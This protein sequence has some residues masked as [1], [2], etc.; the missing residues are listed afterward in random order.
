MGHR[1]NS[2]IFDSVHQHN[3][4]NKT[5]R[6]LTA[7]GQLSFEGI[8]IRLRWTVEELQQ[9]VYVPP[10]CWGCIE[11]KMLELC[12]RPNI[13]GPDCRCNETNISYHNYYLLSPLSLYLKNQ[14]TTTKMWSFIQLCD[15]K[16]TNT[17]PWI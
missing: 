14:Q 15:K 13:Y 16:Q 1:H 17:N 2:N 6:A 5:R 11:P 10:T 12:R 8:Y 7:D 9:F 3:G 4:F